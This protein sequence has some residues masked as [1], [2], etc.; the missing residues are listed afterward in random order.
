VSPN[1]GSVFGQLIFLRT[2]NVEAQNFQLGVL[3]SDRP[4]SALLISTLPHKPDPRNRPKRVLDTGA[5]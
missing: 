4:L 3:K 1:L 2:I 5:H